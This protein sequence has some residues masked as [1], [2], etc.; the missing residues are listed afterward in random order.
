MPRCF[1]GFLTGV[2]FTYEYIDKVFY[3]EVYFNQ[4]LCIGYN[5]P[6]DLSRIARRVGNSRKANKGGF[7]FTLSDKKWNPPI[8]IKKISPTYSFKFSTALNN[9]KDDY[10]SGYF[11]DVQNL[12]EVLLQSRHISLQKAAENLQP[13]TQKMENVTYGRVTKR[14]IN[15]LI[16][17]V[18]TT[19]E[20]YQKLVT[21]LDLYECI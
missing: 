1:V 9:Q 12:A 5:L 10:F 19:F 3:P 7:T 20:V 11:L 17:D 4:V 13:T 2:R 16:S 6:F 15:Y 18:Q 14:F 21:E 8:I